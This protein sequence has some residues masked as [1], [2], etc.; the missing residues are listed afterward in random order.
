MKAV[1]TLGITREDIQAFNEADTI[2]KAEGAYSADVLSDT[3]DDQFVLHMMTLPKNMNKVT[4]SKGRMP[5]K[6]GECLAD[7]EMDYKI[8][9]RI[10]VKSGTDDPLSDTLTTDTYTVVGIGNSPCYISFNRGSTTIGKGTID[11]FLVV[12]EDTFALDTYTEACMQVK[13]TK[14]LTAYTDAYEKK[15]EKATDQIETLGKKRGRIRR[16]ELVNVS[17]DGG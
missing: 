8:G 7:E 17:P 4:V 3:K 16:Q 10:V 1:S 13:G 5:E 12:S 11:G 14:T 15:V 9:D 2:E 6:A